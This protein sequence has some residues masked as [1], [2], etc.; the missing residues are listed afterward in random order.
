MMRG[1]E[2]K[3]VLLLRSSEF[4]STPALPRFAA[5][6]AGLVGPGQV[7]ALCWRTNT[8][9][10][11]PVQVPDG[12]VVRHFERP[13]SSRSISG[14][15]GMPRWW[16]EIWRALE[17]GDFAV[18]QASD[19]FSLLP[20]ILARPFLGCR[21]VADVRDHMASISGSDWG[22]KAKILG[23]VETFLLRRADR[24]IVVDETR[25]E[26]L[27][28]A[29]L[30]GDRVVVVKNLPLADAGWLEPRGVDSVRINFSGFLSA[31]RGATH[32]V[33]GAE[34]AGATLDVVGET[35]EVPLDECFGRSA[36]VVRHGRVGHSRAIELMRDAHLVALLYDP[37]IKANRYAAPNKFYEAMMVGRP[38]LVSRGTPM[39]EWVL[40]HG[41]GYVV[42]YGS[43]SAIGEV[44]KSI[45]ADCAGWLLKCRNA[46][47]LYEREFRWAPE[48]RKLEEAYRTLG[49]GKAEAEPSAAAQG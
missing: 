20:C 15:L 16:L 31:I 46:R 2:P 34:H 48:A 47:D 33:A 4:A 36:S 43:I 10:A 21:V 35:N 30:E 45:R 22:L 37:A 3:R 26:L 44:V 7:E 17:G 18:V 8:R 6:L 38:V 14:W 1:P 11:S 49:L 41:C 19:V 32:L 27:P 39:E 5:V 23:A 9:F 12:L 25:K 29:V 28:H 13:A 24:I 40:Q 42:P